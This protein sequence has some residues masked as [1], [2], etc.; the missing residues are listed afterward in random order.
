[1]FG[2]P[3]RT[4]TWN[5]CL[6]GGRY[7]LFTYEDVFEE[8]FYTLFGFGIQ[9]YGQYDVDLYGFLRSTKCVFA[10]YWVCRASGG[11]DFIFS[12]VAL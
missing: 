2:V 12:A 8:V 11:I 9:M 4:R 6:G 5:S 1:M 7:I 3:T 10:T